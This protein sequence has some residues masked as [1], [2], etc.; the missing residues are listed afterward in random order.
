MPGVD[1]NIYTLIYTL[2]Y[3]YINIYIYIYIKPISINKSD[4]IDSSARILENSLD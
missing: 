1:V 2:I 3:I 4:I